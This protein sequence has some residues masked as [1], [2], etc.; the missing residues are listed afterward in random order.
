MFALDEIDTKLLKELLVDS[1][2]SFRELAKAIGVSPATV[3]NHVQRLES[4]G[5]IQDYSVRLDHERLGYEL[6]VIIEIIVSKGKLLE[7]DEEIS[8]IPNVCAVYDITGETDAMVIAK[9]R[10]RS[11]LSEFTKKLLTMPY[12]E[13]TNTHV[14]LTT[15]LEDFRMQDDMF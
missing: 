12:V 9:F 14:V 1:K 4:G 13:R 2:R 15:V 11:A 3:I 5:I 10:T 6:T 8:K 7:T